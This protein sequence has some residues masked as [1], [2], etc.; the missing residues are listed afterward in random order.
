VNELALSITRLAGVP[1]DGDLLVVGPSLGTSV[2][3]LWSSAAR[4]LG[5]RFEVVGWDLP[6]H[7]HSAP[8][9]TSFSVADLA[10]AVVGLT[11]PLAGHGRRCWYAGV[12]AGGAVGL[13]AAL[14][15]GVFEGVAVIAASARIGEPTGWQERAALVRRAGTSVM[16]EGSAG[17]WFAP[18][19]ID[20][21]P[22]TAG[23]LL[24]SLAE[25]DA[26]SY[27]GVCEALASFDVRDRLPGLDIPVVM[28]P[29]EHDGVVTVDQARATA[30]A[31]PGM[32]LHVLAGCGHLP[33][34]ED[35]A[36]TAAAI[37]TLCT[38]S[39]EGTR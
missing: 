21:H 11:D 2:T 14:D 32:S 17:R 34:A 24:T 3:A 5:D 16:V 31:G 25:T 28:M 37:A 19:F 4:L 33:P 7:G 23:A 15:T 29:G 6:G 8:V 1:G 9:T 35:P 36:Q 10:V 18:G 13:Q 27:A 12:S 26:E 22:D 38:R 39:S 30:D 20:R